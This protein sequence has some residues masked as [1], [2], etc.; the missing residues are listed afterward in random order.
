MGMLADRVD[1][2][3]GVDTHRDAHAVAVVAPSGAVGAH[4]TVGADARGYRRLL[5]FARAHAPGRRVWAIESTGSFGAGLTSFLRERGEWVVEVDRPKRP[6]R[7]CSIR[8]A[9]TPRS[10]AVRG[11]RARPANPIGATRD[12]RPLPFDRTAGI[13]GRTRVWRA[14]RRKS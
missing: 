12:A 4:A 10:R 3:L 7:P 13:L 6:A 9:S 1:H 2:M 11:R 8:S 14:K 5:R